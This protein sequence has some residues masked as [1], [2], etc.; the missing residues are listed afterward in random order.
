MQIAFDPFHRFAYVANSGSHD[1]S[2]YSLDKNTGALTPIGAGPLTT[3]GLNPV[4]LTVDSSGRFVY[5]SHQNGGTGV[6]ISAFSIDQAT[7]V[8]TPIGSVPAG[9]E[10]FSI[11]VDPT[12]HFA[13][14]ASGDP[15][16]PYTNNVVYTFSIDQTTGALAQVGP[17]IP[18]P[19]IAV[20]LSLHP[21]GRFIYVASGISS[22][23]SAYNV[24][25]NTGLLT[26]IGTLPTGGSGPR[27]VAIER[28]GK[29]AYVV[30]VGSNNV[31]IFGIN[32]TSG[33]LTPI[34]TPV[35]APGI[36]ARFLAI[37]P[38]KDFLYVTYSTSTY[39]SAFGINSTTGALTHL[40]VT[41]AG[42]GSLGITVPDLP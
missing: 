28:T 29:F 9:I 24:D 22:N 39:V 14:V 42:N 36:D 23:I 31:S 16:L 32:Q 4:S 1:V 21:S 10:P 34:G 7:G 17:P 6:G 20:H 30:N 11:V 40:D 19:E 35:S 41:P 15:T 18:A 33:A 37:N 26:L 12:G 5:V 2:M 3:G 27:T 25:I 13:Y 8:L 38:S